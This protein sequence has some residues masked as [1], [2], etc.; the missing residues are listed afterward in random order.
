MF[1]H[2]A[3]SYMDMR[4][5]LGLLRSLAPMQHHNRKRNQYVTDKVPFI[6]ATTNNYWDR[7]FCAEFARSL[8]VCL[9]F[10]QVLQLP[11]TVQIY[12]G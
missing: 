4:H 3:G 6:S 7:A 12:A 10:L 5:R 2:Y 1:T 9:G 11:P 8:H